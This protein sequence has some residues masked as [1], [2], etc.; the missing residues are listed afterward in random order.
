MAIKRTVCVFT[1]VLL[2][3]V[4][5]RGQTITQSSNATLVTVSGEVKTPLK[6]TTDLA[7]LPRRTLRAKA[8]DGTEASFEGSR[9]GRNLKARRCGV[10]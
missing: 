1:L 6:L 5:P 4:T 3:L 10:R 8:H 9:A 7:K 2:G